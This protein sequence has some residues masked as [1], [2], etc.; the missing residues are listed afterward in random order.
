MSSKSLDVDRNMRHVK[1]SVFVVANVDQLPELTR[2]DV[3]WNFREDSEMISMKFESSKLIEN[4]QK[5]SK[6]STS[7]G[8]K[9]NSVADKKPKHN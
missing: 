2:I 8:H 9:T 4:R 1:L 6:V 5:L 3:I 7:R